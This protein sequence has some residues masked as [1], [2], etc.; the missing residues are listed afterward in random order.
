MTKMHLLYLI[1]P[2]APLAGAIVA[3]LFGWAIGREN[4]HRVTIAGMLVS[5]VAAALVFHDVLNGGGDNVSVYRWMESGNVRFEIG[6]LVDKLS[7]TM[8]L[9]VTFVSLM[10]HIYTI[11]YMAEDPGYQRFFSYISLF[12]FSMLMLVMANNFLQLFFGWE[13]VGLVSYLLIGFWYTRPTA[14]YA[15]LK[16]FLV[17]RVGD[18]GFLLGIALVLM[19]F[20]TLQYNDVF[21]KAP[22]LA[23]NTIELVSGHA[24]SLMTVICLLLFVGAMGKSAQ[25]PLHVWLPD[26]MEGPTPISALIHAATMVTAGIFMVARMS[27]LFELSDTALSVVMVIGAITAFFMAL[28]AT[29]VYD[30]KRV[31][32]YSTLSQLGYMTVALGASAY[33]AGIFHL[34][35]HAFF[36]AVLFLGAGSVI[37]ALHHEQDMRRMGGL[38]KYMPITY[39]TVLIGALANAGLPPFAGFFSKDTIIEA[40]HASHLPGA[41]FAYLATLFGV[42]V[43]GFYSFRLVFY[44]FHGKERFNDPAHPDVKELEAERAAALAAE[45]AAAAQQAAAAKHDDHGHGSHGHEEHKHDDHKHDAHAHDDHG[46]AHGA[47]HESPWVVTLPLVLLAIPSV[48]AGWVIGTFL[49]GDYFGAAIRFSPAHPVMEELKAE[50]HGVIPM[51]L[52]GLTSITFWFAVGGAAIAWF[53]YIARPD[54][55]AVLRKKAGVLVTILMEKYGLDRLNDWL[56]AGGARAV[57]TGLWKGG[58]VA[59]ID[60]V[61]VN[62]SARTVGWFAFVARE[63][64]SGRLYNYAFAMIIGVLMLL[65]M[66]FL[67]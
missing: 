51:M 38:R 11:G 22:T 12:T 8:M 66:I 41:G 62:G 63:L 16:A 60:G 65:T 3:G 46:H 50:F 25:F 1:V 49:Y 43:G 45:K 15:N 48:C 53:L 36:K 19:Y 56:F 55:P 54:L 64:Q 13:A 61:M 28:I 29:V 33:S 37:I 44:A 23:S 58:D 18:F 24:W 47:P 2:L 59:V 31:V 5:L 26:S 52:H 17:N 35:I 32:A 42:L 9:V 10:V 39:L 27:P 7:A 4:A 34:V 20:G 21:A 14:I 40:V 57:G 6:F 30:I 67:D